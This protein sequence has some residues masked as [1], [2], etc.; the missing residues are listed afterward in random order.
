MTEY[1]GHL[2]C[3]VALA[4]WEDSSDVRIRPGSRGGWEV[5]W[6]TDPKVRHIQLREEWIE[7]GEQKEGSTACSHPVNRMGVEPQGC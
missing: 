1:T 7:C 3:S 4:L 6:I 5:S 2:R